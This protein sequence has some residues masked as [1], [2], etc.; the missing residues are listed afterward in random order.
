MIRGRREMNHA[1]LR[2]YEFDEF[3]SE[4]RYVFRQSTAWN[5]IQHYPFFNE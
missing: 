4:L 1:I 5:F 3:R 2:A